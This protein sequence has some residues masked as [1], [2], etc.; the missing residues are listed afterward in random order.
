MGQSLIPSAGEKVSMILPCLSV[1]ACNSLM[2]LFCQA[3]KDNSYIDVWWG[4]SFIVPNA[5]LVGLQHYA[6][7][8]IDKRTILVNLL[9]SAWGLR[10]AWHIGK[11]HKEE[12]YRYKAMRDRWEKKSKGYYY[13]ASFMY[14]FMM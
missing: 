10:L 11:R 7:H 8:S 1:F 4:L 6:G 3:K 13:F 12:D 9:I 14:V 2:Y 5:V